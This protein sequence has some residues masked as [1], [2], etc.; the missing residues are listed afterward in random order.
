MRIALLAVAAFAAT[1]AFA[2]EPEAAKPI[3]VEQRVDA[4]I[5][6]EDQ[7]RAAASMDELTAKLADPKTAAMISA[8]TVAMTDAMMDMKVGPIIAAAEGRKPSRAE[9]KLSVGDM[10]RRED[11]RAEDKIRA[12]AAQTGQS[13]QVAGAAMAVMLPKLIETF[14]ELGEEMEEAMANLPRPDYPAR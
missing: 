2:A 4:Q 8:I 1:P 14:E 3:S 9:K 7:D 13:V 10:A 12:A 5:A 6:A 11:P